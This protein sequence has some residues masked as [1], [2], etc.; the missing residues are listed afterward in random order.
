VATD[1]EKFIKTKIEDLRPR[2][3]DLSRRNPLISVRLRAN[4]GTLIRAV[5]ELPDV[6]FYKLNNDQE[7]RLAPLP[8]LE[9]DPLDEQSDEFQNALS[10]ARLT[11]ELFETEVEKVDEDEDGHL[12]RTRNIER[13]LKDRVREKLN[14]PPRAKKGDTNLSQHA[15]NNG[16]TPNYDLPS[17]EKEHEDGRH[18][19]NAIQTLLLPQQL[20]RRLNALGTKCRTWQQETGLNVFRVAFGLLEWSGLNERDAVLSPL[21]LASAELK[22]R[23]TQNGS[24]FWVAG[25]GED[26]ETNSVL[27]EKLFRD[28]GVTLPDFQGTSVEEYLSLVAENAPKNMVWRVRRQVAIGIFPSARLAMYH[29]LDTSSQSFKTNE[30]VNALLGGMK[31]SGAS[32]S[33]EVYEIDAPKIESKVP[34]LVLE[35]DCYQFSALVDIANG[36]NLAVEGPPGTGKSQTIINTIAAAMLDGKKVLFVAEKLAAL[37]VVKARLEAI[38]LGEFI[39][40]LQAERS[41]R[42]QIVQSLRERLEIDQIETPATIEGKQRS[43]QNTRDEI[44]RFIELSTQQFAETG[45][46]I[47]DALTTEVATREYLSTIPDDVQQQCLLPAELANKEGIVRLKSVGTALEQAILDQTNAKPNWKG[48]KLESSNLFE[49]Q[50]ALNH[51]KTAALKFTQLTEVF[52][53]ITSST[54]L[55]KVEMDDLLAVFPLLVDLSGLGEEDVCEVIID[56]LK[57]EFA[58]YT[59]G[60]IKDCERLLDT[61]QRLK[62]V[63]VD[64]E[65]PAGPEQIQRIIELCSEHQFETLDEKLLVEKGTHQKN[66]VEQLKEYLAQCMSLLAI[67][68][69]A[70]QWTL[71]QLVVA[72]KL[73][74]EVGNQGLALRNSAT[75]DPSAPVILHRLCQSGETIKARRTEL[76]RELSFAMNIEIGELSDAISA[77]RRAS[78]FS[79]F[80]AAF[81][82]A[83]KLYSSITKKDRFDRK[84]A[85]ETLEKLLSW[86]RETMDFSNNKQAI[87]LFGLHFE[88]IETDFEPFKNLA[89]FYNGINEKFAG[90]EN[91]D[92]RDFL[93]NAELDE[94]D[95][96][97]ETEIVQDVTIERVEQILS[98]ADAANLGFSKG[99]SQIQPMLNIFKNA[100]TVPVGGLAELLS[101][102]V[103]M[104]NQI[105]RLENDQKA[106]KILRDLFRGLETELGFIRNLLDWCSGASG[107]A[108]VISLLLRRKTVS[109]IVVEL[110]NLN[111]AD[112]EAKKALTQLCEATGLSKIDLMKNKTTGDIATFLADAAKDEDGLRVHAA[113]TKCLTDIQDS[114]V[115]PIAEYLMSSNSSEDCA[116]VLEAF[117]VNKIAR[118]VMDQHSQELDAFSGKR[119]NDLRS[120]L[121]SL[122]R[123]LIKLSRQKIR[124]QLASKSH[125]PAGHGTG[126]KRTWTDL[127]LI[128]NETEKKQ[129]FISARDLT[130]RAAKALIELKPCWMMS[131]LA[132]AQY[133]E[134]GAIEFDLVIIDEAS[135]MPPE[136]ALGALM[137]GTQVMIVGDT[138]QLPPTNFFKSLLAPDDDDDTD[139]AVLEE[140]ILEM[141]NATFRPKRRLN[142]HYRSRHSSL[143]SYSNRMVYDDELIVFPAA[144]EISP[145]MGVFYKRVNGFYKTGTNPIEAKI[146]VEAVLEHMRA[147]SERS[148]GVV[149]LNRKQRDLILEEFEHALSRDSNAQSFVDNWRTEND[150]LEEF[151]VKN[152]ENVQGDERDVIFI[153]TVYGP[154][155]EGVRPHQR[156]GPVN[157]LA[158]KRRLNVLFSRAKQ[159]IV[160]Y[161]SMS[162]ADVRASAHSNPGTFMLK[163]WL[164]YSAT[165]VL[166]AGQI[167]KKEPDSLFECYVMDQIKA[168]GCEAIPQIGVS[169]YFID[170]GVRHPDWPHGFLLGVECDGAT[171]HSSKSA[172]DRDRYRQEI[173]EGLGW[174]FHRIW[175]PDWFNNQRRE[176]EE[177]RKVIMARLQQLKETEASF[178]TAPAIDKRVDPEPVEKEAAKKWE[179]QSQVQHDGMTKT[180]AEMQ[181][182]PAA[183]NQL[184]VEVGDTVR[185]RYLSGDNSTLQFQIS[186]NESAPNKGIIHAQSPIANALLGAEKGDEVEVL[187]GSRVRS[188]EI[189]RITKGHP[190]S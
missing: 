157:G 57:P 44:A 85:V 24:E 82:K 71:S 58:Q 108:E 43:F 25:I 62:E 115:L 188:A 129:R 99:V 22:K 65:S 74:D 103:D 45:F 152:L 88:G 51:A 118:Q 150:G 154:E 70:R 2:L 143:I 121:A 175:Y 52:E 4:S 90:P 23:R 106:Q 48:A 111:E 5:D 140:S 55:Q 95:V 93:K 169:G 178:L 134:K 14:M 109:E 156:F 173:L 17:S 69:T 119:L 179:I 78:L 21:V 135:Q 189:E 185:V 159:K 132:V 105:P 41:S 6:L 63:L 155:K 31:N 116:R 92:I 86:T 149:T 35:A 29:D 142:W 171:Y 167:T 53:A 18:S 8:P 54:L 37:N 10:N 67:R 162:G 141:A 3:L 1:L 38:G 158:G 123:D 131:P 122:D 144:S 9:D 80:S 120:L 66:A 27:A 26:A 139:D 148:L 151:F 138:N 20:E 164:E 112:L 124:A 177:L 161:S 184:A 183:S 168:M 117:L 19:D 145:N 59:A 75:A 77:L 176:A 36:K 146:V 163:G 170:I 89:E 81:R 182:I 39:L 94:I 79:T 130:R 91:R 33:A 113:G 28:F 160:T 42:A 30:I 110:R 73:V 127:S 98:V 97:P 40:P 56:L 133:I 187:I 49:I 32:H 100:P 136:N 84:R 64:W 137:R 104:Q 186:A 60:F 87:A 174:H 172:R 96:L 47:R 102:L 11:D 12:D 107:Y 61:R 165:G 128:R 15:R 153:G 126:P 68:P 50:S 76:E 114:G 83:K 181:S 46:T 34:N 166:D 101:Q 13:A 147:D 190:P 7:M 72:K 180:Q 125:P 16:I